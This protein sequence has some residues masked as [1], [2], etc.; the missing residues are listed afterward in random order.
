MRLLKKLLPISSEKIDKRPPVSISGSFPITPLNNQKIEPPKYFFPN[1]NM[2]AEVLAEVE[3]ALHKLPV[4]SSAI[5]VSTGAILEQMAALG[6]KGP[7]TIYAVDI[8]PQ[9]LHWL[10]FYVDSFS[11][12][13]KLSFSKSKLN[14]KFSEL[15]K[16]IKELKGLRLNDLNSIFPQSQDELAFYEM[17]FLLEL[18]SK[19]NPFL[20]G[21]NSN[22]INKI[23][24]KNIIRRWNGFK[25]K[26]KKKHVFNSMDN[27]NRA[28][29]FLK[30]KK[31]V[32]AQVDLFDT[33][34]LTK[35][36]QEAKPCS[37][38]YLSNVAEWYNKRSEHKYPKKC[39]N[40]IPIQ[41][42]RVEDFK[43]H[44]SK[45]VKGSI[46]EGSIILSSRSFGNVAGT[47]VIQAASWNKYISCFSSKDFFDVF[48][49]D[50]KK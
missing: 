17:S 40:K 42:K 50:K 20:D 26:M 2:I 44:F 43:L 35:L 9:Q 12:I 25:N 48:K 27:F 47:K 36:A 28:K 18:L 49:N 1:D 22:E 7:S 30:K 16:I 15:I 46:A 13:S 24:V 45:N 11:K 34:Q 5:I 38:W 19:N 33:N 29:L 4:N 10:K 31:I 32:I 37:Y 3:K 23:I 6:K 39:F 8:S 41:D 14:R 21:P